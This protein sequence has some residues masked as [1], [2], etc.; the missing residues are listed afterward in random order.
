MLN[1]EYYAKE[2]VDIVTSED[3]GNI[4]VDIHTKKPCKCVALECDNCLLCGDCGGL[5]N[6]WANSEYVES[7]EITHAEKAILENLDEII[8]WIARDNDGKLICI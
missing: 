5:R 3:D 4:A 2:I 6:K 8:K 1:K 7:I